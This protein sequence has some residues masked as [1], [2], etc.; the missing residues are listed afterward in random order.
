VFAA[1]LVDLLGNVPAHARQNSDRASGP[2]TFDLYQ[3]INLGRPLAPQAAS[4]FRNLIV[5]SIIRLCGY[6][7]FLK[8][9]PR[10]TVKRLEAA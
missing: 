10:R 7:W 5:L 9:A 8:L 2:R 1:G 6:D 3:S 4:R